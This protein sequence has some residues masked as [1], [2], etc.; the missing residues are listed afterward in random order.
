MKKVKSV[1]YFKDSKFPVSDCSDKNGSSGQNIADIINN[2]STDVSVTGTIVESKCL[3]TGIKKEQ[4]ARF[5]LKDSSGK[6]GILVFPLLYQKCGNKILKNGKMVAVDGM[7]SI[8]A[9]SYE[10]IARKIVPCVT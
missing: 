7:L 3:L 6:I 1:S 9:E 5:T 2:K 4:Y 8:E 10:I